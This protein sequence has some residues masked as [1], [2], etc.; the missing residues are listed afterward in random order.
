MLPGEIAFLVFVIV[1]FVV[2]GVTLGW[3]SHL[4]TKTDRRAA[5]ASDRLPAGGHV[6]QQGADG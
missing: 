6:W 2:F 4:D 3:L 5:A 1:A